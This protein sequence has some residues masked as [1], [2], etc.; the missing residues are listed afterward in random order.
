M[1]IYEL[2]EQWGKWQFSDGSNWMP[3]HNITDNTISKMPKKAGAYVIG[4]ANDH[5]LHR[6]L[7]KDP[8]GILDIGDADNLQLRLSNFKNCASHLGTGGHMTGWR[9][10]TMGILKR[11]NISVEQLQVSWYETKDKK[12][13]Y[14]CQLQIFK[15]YLQLFGE[16]PPLNYKF[17]WASFGSYTYM[18]TQ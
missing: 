7:E 13:A 5:G 14:L 17:N 11:M 12:E 9:L 2:L 6:L 18:Y 16:L 10:G 3:W 4:L 8:H 15:M 1:E